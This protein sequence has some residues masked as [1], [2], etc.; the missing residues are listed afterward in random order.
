MNISTDK[1]KLA[2]ARNE[3]NVKDLS[4]ESGIPI[5]TIYSWL[6]NKGRRNP[7]TKNL[8]KIAKVLKVDVTELI[9]D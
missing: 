6:K 7:N 8:G 5:N 4:I 9:E 3:L 2:L 1:L